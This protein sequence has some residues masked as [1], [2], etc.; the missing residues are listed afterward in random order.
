MSENNE[1]YG[2]LK[3]FARE[4]RILLK[5]ALSSFLCYAVDYGLYSFFVTVFKGVG[6]V[7]F[8]N[9]C[10]RAISATLNF[11][12]NRKFV[13]KDSGNAGKKAVEYFALAAAV[14]VGSTFVLSFCVS[15]FA[16]NKYYTKL[17][18]DI[19]F[20]VVNW[21]IQKFVIFKKN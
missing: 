13:F 16:F 12:L 15:R 17:A 21:L 7:K 8:V 9:V 18:V 14:L 1:S 10:S 11:F 4:N 5:F 2:K 3:R 20:F 19:V 6:S